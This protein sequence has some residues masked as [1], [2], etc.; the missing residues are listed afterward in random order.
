MSILSTTSSQNEFIPPKPP[1]V[2]Y[3]IALYTITSTTKSS[4]DDSD[5][6]SDSDSTDSNDTPITFHNA[7]IG[8]DVKS[9][10]VELCKTVDHTMRARLMGQP[11]KIVHNMKD[12]QRT[13]ALEPLVAM[14]HDLIAHNKYRHVIPGKDGTC[15]HLCFHKFVGTNSAVT[16]A[17]RRFDVLSVRDCVYIGISHDVETLAVTWWVL[18]N[19]KA[20]LR[21]YNAV[22]WAPAGA[23]D[24]IIEYGLCNNTWNYLE[25]IQLT[26]RARKLSMHIDHNTTVK[27]AIAFEQDPYNQMMTDMSSEYDEMPPLHGT[28]NDDLP[29]DDERE[30]ET[31]TTTTAYSSTTTSSSSTDALMLTSPMHIDTLS[32][33]WAW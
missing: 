21:H 3:V 25:P 19:A 2:F 7:I 22:T 14:V 13:Q 6:E 9:I 18:V 24:C 32:L 33:N 10:L 31:N 16:V 8:K 20:A 29:V 28:K 15:H 17:D 5:R 30:K 23:V 1:N 26:T 27:D 12:N 4:D 11:R